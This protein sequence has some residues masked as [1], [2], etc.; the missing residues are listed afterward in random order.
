MTILQVLVQDNIKTPQD[1]PCAANDHNNIGAETYSAKSWEDL[2]CILDDPQWTPESYPELLDALATPGCAMIVL[3]HVDVEDMAGRLA[4]V[5]LSVLHTV[6]LR[7]CWCGVQVHLLRAAM[8]AAGVWT[9]DVKL[10]KTDDEK[11]FVFTTSASAALEAAVK[12]FAVLEAT[13]DFLADHHV[14]VCCAPLAG[15]SH[16]CA[17]F[18]WHRGGAVTHF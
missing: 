17:G 9:N 4:L 3:C 8:D 13:N 15:L 2:S 12:M 14:E 6:F 5:S 16:V 11:F 18:G 7:V 1:T 10:V